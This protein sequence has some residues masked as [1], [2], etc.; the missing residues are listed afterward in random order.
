MK[1]QFCIFILLFLIGFLSAQEE[2]SFTPYGFAQY[3]LRTRHRS[4]ATDEAR[5]WTSDYANTI[6]YYAGFRAVLNQSLGFGMQIGNDWVHTE[7][8]NYLNNNPVIPQRQ[9]PPGSVPVFHLAYATYDPGFFDLTLGIVPLLSY[10]PLDLLERSL[11]TGTYQGT[12]FFTWPVI[13]NNSMMG[14]QLGFP[15][16]EDERTLRAEL[17]TTVIDSRL[18]EITANEGIV[19]PPVSA[20]SGVML[21]LT[22]PFSTDVFMVTPQVLG[23]FNRNYNLTR[24]RGDHEWAGGFRAEYTVRGGVQVWGSFA[25]G[26]I[27]NWKSRNPVNMRTVIDTVGEVYDHRGLISSLGVGIGIGPGTLVTD[28]KYSFHTDRQTDEEYYHY[29]LN[30]LYYSLE[31][32]SGLSIAPRV[33]NF[34]TFNPSGSEI[35]MLLEIR[36][37]IM[38]TATF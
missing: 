21:L 16:F 30:D 19:D 2:R 13:T 6:S 14:L 24:G 23:V 8:V 1:H 4:A 20:S 27:A 28:V 22:L 11:S 35:E 26:G 7:D 18:G 33:R 36:P 15:L 37:E 31:V 3:R 12:A 34:M 38:V 10:G 5:V 32:R 17:F 29:V 25:Y 9:F